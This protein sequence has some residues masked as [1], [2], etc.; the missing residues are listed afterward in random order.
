MRLDNLKGVGPKRVEH[1]HDNGIESVRDIARTFPR[2]YDHKQ[3]S[4]LTDARE[5]AVYI[6]GT[7]TTDV[8]LYFIRTNL[9]RLTFTMEH[10][11]QSLKIAVFNQRFLKRT[12]AINTSIVVYGK[13]EVSGSNLFMTAQKV[14]LRENFEEGIFP[15]YGLKNINDKTFSKLV[16]QALHFQAAI[17]KEW[18]PERLIE[19]NS[20]LSPRSTLDALHFP[21]DIQTLETA[22]KRLKY[23]ELIV[24]QL[25]MT[26]MK[27]LRKSSG[28]PKII[29]KSRLDDFI[30]HLPFL[31]TKAQTNAL[32]EIIGDLE[33]PRR[34]ARILQGDTGS[35]KTIVALIAALGVIQSGEQVALMAPTQILAKQHYETLSTMLAP[36]IRIAYL[37]QDASDK[38]HVLNDLKTGHVDMVVG[39]HMLFS[40]QTRYSNLGLIITDEQHRFGV[41]QRSRLHEK[42]PKADWLYLSATPI[43]RTLA[44]SLYGS[45]DVSVIDEKPNQESK[46]I[47][48]LVPLK[49]ERALRK[50][51]EGAAK[52]SQQI[53]VVTPYIDNTSTIT[54]SLKTLKRSY[55][56]AYPSLKSVMLHGRMDSETQQSVMNDFKRRTYDIMLATT[57]IE[58]GVD[59]PNATVMIVYHAERMGLAQ[60]HQ[61]RGRVGRGKKN[62]VCLLVYETGEAYDRLKVLEETNDGFA[63]SESDLATRGH[64]DLFGTLQS[65]YLSFKHTDL[66]RD[67][68]LIEAAKTDAQTIAKDVFK[69]NSPYETLR[70]TVNATLENE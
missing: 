40:T 63:I 41:S 51:I 58:V 61:L 8:K 50:F 30:E 56:A 14:Y 67:F 2:R 47:T 29:N 31:M 42:S 70:Q 3:L 62:G 5:E 43:P 34:M 55:D 24:H 15:V 36:D 52:A 27:S 68:T 64:G 57:I 60:L 25:K 12:L 28:V 22:I 53:F 20:L 10:E 33:S 44:Q 69:T 17:G 65:G 66:T 59:F 49:N 7:I 23:E 9:S 26:R 13:V 32:G 11:N 19:K 6:A 48:R 16:E 46:V 45:L 39:T 37:T 4:T 38:H 54:H 1:M 18:L 21:A 35:G